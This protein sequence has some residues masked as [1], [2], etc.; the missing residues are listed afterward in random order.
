MND[1]V[2]CRDGHEQIVHCGGDSGRCPLCQ[3]K[4][5][6]QDSVEAIK[7]MQ[8]ETA[9]LRNKLRKIKKNCCGKVKS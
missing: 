7:K 9:K 4:S 2:I 5:H 3:L 6:L 8:D 1:L